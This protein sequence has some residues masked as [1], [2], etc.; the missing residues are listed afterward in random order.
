MQVIF[1]KKR[2]F[3]AESSFLLSSDLKAGFATGAND[4]V[5][6]FCPRETEDRLAMVA[7]SV[8]VC[9]AVTEAIAE[10]SEETAE[11][12]VFAAPQ[13]NLAGERTGENDH[14]QRGRTKKIGDHENRTRRGIGQKQRDDGIDENDGNI[15]T[16]IEFIQGVGSVSPVHPSV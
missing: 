16:Q 12:L 13:L 8:N 5:L 15:N 9:L 4:R 6:S 7:F 1:H 3:D 14:N 11:S 2:T 10:Q